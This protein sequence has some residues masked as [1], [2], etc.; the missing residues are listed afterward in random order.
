MI[1]MDVEFADE[2]LAV[3]WPGQQETRDRLAVQGHQGQV[4][5]LP[6]FLAGQGCPG[7]IGQADG[8]KAGGGRP[9]DGRQP[10]VVARTGLPDTIAD[11]AQAVAGAP[12]AARAAAT[13]RAGLDS[14]GTPRSVSS[15]AAAAIEAWA[16][17]TAPSPA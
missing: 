16:S 6:R 1:G 11:Q 4:A 15:G 8:R 12:T 7:D 10:L 2:N 14:T 5:A 9:L 3:L 17:T 13:P